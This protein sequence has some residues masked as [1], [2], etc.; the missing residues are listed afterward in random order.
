M[1]ATKM[2]GIQDMAT[3]TIHLFWWDQSGLF[4]MKSTI[5]PRHRGEAI[6][7]KHLT[8]RINPGYRHGADDEKAF[9]HQAE[10][11]NI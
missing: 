3:P 9:K 4:E 10:T 7:R 1:V 5:P 2:N 11:Y 6:K 8:V